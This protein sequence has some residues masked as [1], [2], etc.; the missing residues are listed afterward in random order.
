M[1]RAHACY[2]QR[3]REVVGSTPAEGEKGLNYLFSLKKIL[4]K[5]IVLYMMFANMAQWQSAL[6]V[7]LVFLLIS[8]S[9]TYQLTQQIFGQIIGI[10]DVV[11]CPT[12]M[13]LVLHTVVFLI[14]VRILMEFKLLTL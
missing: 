8:N 13:G 3:E 4:K 6:I 14:I 2:T 5:S 7:T 11:G 1:V 10:A 9:Y 12:M